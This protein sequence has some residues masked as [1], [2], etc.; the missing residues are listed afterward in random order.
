M[1]D[2]GVTYY[3]LNRFDEAEQIVSSL[4]KRY[5]ENLGFDHPVTKSAITNLAAIYKAQGREKEAKK[6]QEE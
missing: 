4:L 6:L 5:R 3:Y 2:L 1:M